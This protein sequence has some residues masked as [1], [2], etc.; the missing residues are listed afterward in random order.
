MKNRLYK[1][2]QANSIYFEENKKINLLKAEDDISKIV[3]N[4]KFD[5]YFELLDII[6]SGSHGKVYKS[7]FR[8]INT[9]KFAACKFIIPKNKE[10]SQRN[11]EKKG[12]MEI[13]LHSKLKFKNIPDIYGYYKIQGGTCIAME[14]EKF[15]DLQNFKYNLLKKKTFSESLLSYLSHEILDAISFIHRNKIMHM[16]IK[17]ENILIDEFLNVK[18][19]DFSISFKYSSFNKYIQLPRLGTSYFMSPEVLNNEK[20]LV[21]EASKIDIY[22]FGVLLYKL[23]FCDYPY[24]LRNLK[25]TEYES[26]L[27]NIRENELNFLEEKGHSIMF[28]NFLRKCLEKNIKKRYNIYEAMQDPWIKASR[29]I[30]E[31][32]EKINDVGKFLISIMVNDIIEFNKYVNINN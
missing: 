7:K 29:I 8:K 20:I 14:Y 15:G 21:E 9:N 31:Q 19:T 16:D 22:S 32:K 27:K 2:S 13:F 23:A 26:I 30:L 6:S 1:E 25:N 4:T 5:E 11:D 18:L 17:P 3:K 24:D 10:N 28:K 12:I